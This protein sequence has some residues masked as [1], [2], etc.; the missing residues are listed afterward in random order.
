MKILSPILSQ[1]FSTP[2]LPSYPSSPLTAG[3]QNCQSLLFGVQQSDDLHICT[4]PFDSQPVHN[5]GRNMESRHFPQFWL[6]FLAV[7]EFEL[8][9]SC[10]QGR[11]STTSITPSDLFALVILE[12]GSCFLARPAWTVILLYY[13]SGPYWDTI[14]FLVMNEYSFNITEHSITSFPH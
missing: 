7:L 3:S 9:A 11:C 13:A 12:I 10:L 4:D 5:S 14:F 2:G 1:Y 8:R 6:F